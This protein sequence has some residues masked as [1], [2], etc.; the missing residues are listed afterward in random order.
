MYYER[1]VTCSMNLSLE[2]QKVMFRREKLLVSSVIHSPGLK[3]EVLVDCRIFTFSSFHLEPLCQFQPNFAVTIIRRME[4][5]VL[6]IRNSS[7]LKKY[8]M[9]CNPV[10]FNQCGG[11]IKAFFQT[12]FIVRKC[13]QVRGVVYGSLLSVYNNRK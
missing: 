6:Q 5:K 10:S 9:I 4:F 8:T 7:I 13:L 12:C 3:A 11:I 1:S 2:F